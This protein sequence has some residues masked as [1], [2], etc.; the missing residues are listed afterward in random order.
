MQHTYVF[1]C[2]GYGLW[3]LF[4][5]ASRAGRLDFEYE[6]LYYGLRIES[7]VYD[8]KVDLLPHESVQCELTED[9]VDQEM[10]NSHGNCELT[11]ARF[12][13]PRDNTVTCRLNGGS[14]YA[15]RMDCG[16]DCPQPVPAPQSPYCKRSKV[17]QP[18]G[19]GTSKSRLPRVWTISP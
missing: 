13:S 8:L 9:M 14:K 17:M 10:D 15:L 2:R 16:Q 11:Y 19:S 4:S 12:L 7:D 6:N 3:D 5:V 1:I 18:V